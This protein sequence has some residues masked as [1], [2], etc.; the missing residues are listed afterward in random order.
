MTLTTDAGLIRHRVDTLLEDFLHTQENSAELPELDLFISLL[1]DHLAAGGKR[2]RPLMCV[3]GWYTATDREPPPLVYRV[4]ASLE[5]FHAFALIH[6]DIMDNSATRRGRPTA[7]RAL[8]ALHA[9]RPD[10]DTFGINAAILLGDLAFGW[11]YDLLHATGNDADNLAATWP[12]LNALRTETLIGQYLDLHAAGQP[13]PD[14]TLP[15][16]V[17]RYKTAK[18]TIERPLHLG[19][20]LAGAAPSLLATLTAYALPL[21]EAFQ[22]RDDLLGVFGD[23]Q[24]TGKSTLED[25][26]DGKHTVLIATALAHATPDQ[27][28][29]LRSHLGTPELTPTAATAIRDVLEATGARDAVEQMIRDRCDRALRALQHTQVRPQTQA[30]LQQMVHRLTDRMT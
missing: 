25:L 12:I 20:S 23:P 15:W 1:R 19:A 5:L 8:A 11:S 9:H 13:T 22:L 6:D 29:L 30:L 27:E 4:A 2:I 7:H 18:Y 16:R 10:P 24:H 17:I 26:R 21:G 3:T 14:A 28:H